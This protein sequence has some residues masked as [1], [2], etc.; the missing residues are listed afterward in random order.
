[1]KAA[2]VAAALGASKLLIGQDSQ[3]KRG[4][5]VRWG[6]LK[7][8]LAT[9]GA[10]W[11]SHPEGDLNLIQRIR[12]VTNVDLAFDF[13]VADVADLTQM[14]EFP[15]IFM[16]AQQ[17][18]ALSDLHRANIREY[19]R[20][21]GFLFIDD[22]MAAPSQ[23]DVFY[24]AMRNEMRRILP[25]ARYDRFDTDRNHEIFRCVYRMPDGL[26]QGHPRGRNNGLWGVYDKDRLVALMCSNDFHCAWA[27]WFGQQSEELALRIGV[28]IYVYAMSH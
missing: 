27:Q 2:I 14:T 18:A 22:C 6:R 15:F 3:P 10:K 12:T 5:R 9:A 28:N 17:P 11:Y 16:H 8:P 13:G 21:G 7:F 19:L 4:G 1:M 23:P 25:A 26:P 24:K 20:R